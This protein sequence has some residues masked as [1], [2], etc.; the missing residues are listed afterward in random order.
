MSNLLLII[1]REY[2]QRVRKKSFIITTLLMPV[3]FLAIACIPGLLMSLN[4]SDTKKIGVIDQSGV[5]MASLHDTDDYTF[6]SLDIDPVADSLAN[7]PQWDAFLIIGPDV[8]DNVNDI[9]LFTQGPSSIMMEQSIAGQLDRAI[10]DYRLAQLD[11]GGVREILQQV[12]AD[13]SLKTYR[14]DRSDEGAVQSSTAISYLIGLALAFTLYMFLMIYGQMIMNSIIEEKSTRVLDLLVTSVKPIDLMMG[15]IL[16]VGLVAITQVLLWCVVLLAI[17]TIVVPL[18]MGPE[19]VSEVTAFNQGT[20]DMSTA[21]LD[22]TS[23]QG[24]SL[25]VD[26]GFLIGVLINLVLFLV[27]GFL[28]YSSIYAAIGS[29]VDNIQ[30]ASQLQ[31]IIVIPLIVGFF[32]SS[33]SANNPTSDVAFWLSMIPFTSPMVMLTRIPYGV[34]VWEIIVSLVLL[35]ITF[36]AMTWLAAKIYRIGVFMHGKKPSLKDLYAWVRYK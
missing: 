30:D 15:K 4:T 32:A 23:L 27:G 14:L 26:P 6:T 18:L 10:E 8:I 29:T 16:G 28:L 24:L 17:G 1:Q 7:H 20:L 21:Q 34:P 31:S 35:Y 11:M 3:F 2:L 36:M 5:L 13:T 12:Q 9:S 33:F 22:N 25:I 19:I